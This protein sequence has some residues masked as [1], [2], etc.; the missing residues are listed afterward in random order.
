MSVNP[1]RLTRDWIHLALRQASSYQW[2][3]PKW[4]FQEM[5]PHG[6]ML[7][8]MKFLKDKKANVIAMKKTEAKPHWNTSH[9][10]G[11]ILCVTLWIKGR[12]HHL[13]YSTSALFTR[14]PSAYHAES[15]QLYSGSFCSFLGLRIF[16]E[17][18]EP[19]ASGL[20]GDIIFLF[21]VACWR[22]RKWH[23]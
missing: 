5:G 7:A 14:L 15:S 22:T 4:K 9:S 18:S 19:C 1:S 16:W 13:P 8:I 20:S 23:L 21:W 3:K 11:G 10:R 17:L 2:V 12:N 6:E